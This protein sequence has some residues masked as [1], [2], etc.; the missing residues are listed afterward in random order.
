MWIGKED[1][2]KAFTTY[3]SVNYEEDK[4]KYSAVVVIVVIV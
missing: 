2:L 1:I 4:S 3:Y